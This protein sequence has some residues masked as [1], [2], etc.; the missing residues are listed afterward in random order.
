MLSSASMFAGVLIR[1]AVATQGH[2][3]FLARSQ[4]HPSCADLYALTTLKTRWMFHLG[5]RGKMST[6]FVSHKITWSL[7]TANNR[8]SHQRLHRQ[9]RCDDENLETQSSSC[10]RPPREIFW[11]V[12]RRSARPAICA[13]LQLETRLHVNP[14]PAFARLST[15]RDKHSRCADR[16]KLER[17][18]AISVLNE[19]RRERAK[20]HPSSRKHQS[21]WRFKRD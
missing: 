19:G 13:S 6:G 15:R 3:A 18:F 10:T 21:G 12:R 5:D 9:Q 7:N 20:A 8:D 17:V 11:R 2:S 1:R 4:M 16:G 14:A